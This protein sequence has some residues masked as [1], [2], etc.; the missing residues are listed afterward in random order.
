[1]SSSKR[2]SPSSA[3]PKSASRTSFAPPS[4]VEMD[5][6]Q[7]EAEQVGAPLQGDCGR[8]GETSLPSSTISH[9]SFHA[10]RNILSKNGDLSALLRTKTTFS[11]FSLAMRCIQPM[12]S[13][14]GSC[15]ASKTTHVMSAPAALRRAMR[16]RS[17]PSVPTALWRPGVSRRT[18]CPRGSATMPRIVLRVVC[19][20]GDTIE[21][22]S[23]TS[24]FTSVDL[25]AFV[26]PTTATV[27]T[28]AITERGSSRQAP[29]LRA[30]L[31]PG[32]WCLRC[33]RGRRRSTCRS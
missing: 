25:P 3:K 11:G 21:T 14:C 29:R 19:S 2:S 18:S 33:C 26:R 16:L 15:A 1:M 4:V 32:R 6:T 12:S 27:A 17:V 7:T 9:A 5:L 23:P 30:S 24:A 13:S 20:T 28:S 22:F 31:F 8:L 10:S